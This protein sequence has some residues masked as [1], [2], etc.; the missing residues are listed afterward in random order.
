MQKSPSDFAENIETER[1]EDM[2]CPTGLEACCR[3]LE[4]RYPSLQRKGWSRNA[5]G[6]KPRLDLGP[7]GFRTVNIFKSPVSSS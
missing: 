3:A 6:R 2:E 7:A 4:E 5:D 1:A